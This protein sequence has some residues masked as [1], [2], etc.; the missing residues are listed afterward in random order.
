MAK[1]GPG[2][3]GIDAANPA[4]R[5]LLCF[6]F[7]LH[8]STV[9]IFNIVVYLPAREIKYFNFEVV[10]MRRPAA[11][12]AAAASPNNARLR[13]GGAPGLPEIVL[14]TLEFATLERLRIRQEGIDDPG[15]YAKLFPGE[16]RD[17]WQRL[18]LSL[19]RARLSLSRALSSQPR[20]ADPAIPIYRPADGFEAFIEWEDGVAPR[21][22]LFAPPVK[23]LWDMN[24]DSLER[25][26]EVVLKVSAE[27]RVISVWSP[28]SGETDL[29][30]AV[31]LSVL[32]YRFEPVLGDVEPD[33]SEGLRIKRTAQDTAAATL[34][35]RTARNAP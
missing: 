25:P 26:I 11:A 8:L 32:K 31:Q 20:E 33:E 22:L 2:L 29:I 17:P 24:P 23:A 16:P 12:T 6:S 13:L 21:R 28:T 18:T 7:L 3:E 1:R 9:T 30:D 15:L 27:G 4:F 19:G 10:E 35:I 5:R 34:Y 14:P